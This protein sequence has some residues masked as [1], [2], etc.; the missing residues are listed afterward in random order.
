ML[1]YE[2]L[3]RPHVTIFAPTHKI[4]LRLHSKWRFQEWMTEL[5]LSVPQ[6][7]RLID[8]HSLAKHVKE[9]GSESVYKP[10]WSRFGTQVHISPTNVDWIKSIASIL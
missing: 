3:L 9:F 4:A 8:H 6:T 5:G 7:Q 10:E 1:A 2:E